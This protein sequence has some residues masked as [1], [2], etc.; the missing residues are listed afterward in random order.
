VNAVTDRF[1][2]ILAVLP[3]VDYL[4]GNE[5]EVAQFAKNLKLEGDLPTVM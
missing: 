5:E 2:E 4:F 1:N 3:Y